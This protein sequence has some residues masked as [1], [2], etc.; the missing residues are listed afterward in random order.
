MPAVEKYQAEKGIR[1]TPDIYKTSAGVHH[2]FDAD[3]C[4]WR[5]VEFI[6]NADSYDIS[7]NVEVSYMAARAIG[8]YQ[9]FLNTIDPEQPCDTIKSFHNLPGRLE[10]FYDTIASCD[11]DLLANAQREVEL[12][13][14]FAFIEAETRNIVGSL[15]PRVTHNDT[16]LNNILFKDGKCLVIDLDTVM[17]GFVMF[18]FGD[19]VRTFTSPALEDE[20][21]LLK[22]QFRVDHFEALSK[23]YLEVLKHELSVIEK[24]SLLLG[25]LNI[26]YE[27]VLRF[28]TDYLKGNVYYKVAYP[29]HNLIRTRTQL[30]LLELIISQRTEL[31]QIIKHYA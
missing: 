26:I 4:A 28:L 5:L 20:K 31:E 2:C 3:N 17:R 14:Q 23:G 27:Q 30:K 10:V 12:S 1:I 13:K 19:M 7:P 25:A 18:D 11:K 21:D 6:P 15:T 8:T 22:T 16:K 29:E 9:V 24:E